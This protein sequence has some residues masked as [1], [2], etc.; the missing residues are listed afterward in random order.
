M[1]IWLNVLRGFLHSNH[2]LVENKGKIRLDNQ[3]LLKI[4]QL[5]QEAKGFLSENIHPRLLVEQILLE[6]P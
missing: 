4:T 2:N 5:T 1:D 6:I 3:K